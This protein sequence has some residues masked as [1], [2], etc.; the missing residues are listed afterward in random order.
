[1]A[2]SYREYLK[3]KKYGGEGG[4]TPSPTLIS[5]TIN[6]NG[7]YLPEDD[8]ADGY[9]S[10]SVNVPEVSDIAFVPPQKFK[11]NGSNLEDYK[12]FGSDG[13]V[14]ETETGDLPLTFT[15][16]EDKLRDWEIRGNDEPGTEQLFDKSASTSDK[17]VGNNG[18]E[19]TSYGRSHSDYIPVTTGSYYVSNILQANQFYQIVGFDENK[20]FTKIYNFTPLSYTAI[21]GVVNVEETAKYIII[22]YQSMNENDVSVTKGSTAPDHYIPYQQGV[23][24]RT[25][26]VCIAPTAQTKTNDALSVTTDGQGRYN[27]SISQTISTQTEVSFDLP[28]FTM[29][30]SVGQGGNGTFSMFNTTKSGVYIAFYY[31]NTQVEYWYLSEANRQSN[32]YISMGNKQ[33]NKIVF[34]TSGTVYAGTVECAIM[35]T[36]D[37]ILP[38]E[39]TPY[40][41]Q[42]PLTVSQS[43][44]TDKNYNIYIGDSPLTA[45]QSISKTSTGIDI[46]TTEGDNTIGTTLYNKP[47]TSVTYAESGG[48]GEESSGSYSIPVKINS[49][50]TDIPIGDT[51]L[52]EDE[53]VSY[54]E[55]KIY[56]YVDGTLTP[57]DPPSALP[58]IATAN[59]VNELSVETDIQPELVQIGLG[60]PVE[61]IPVALGTKFITAND[62]YDASDDSLDGYSSVTVNVPEK[63]LTTKTITASGTYNAVDDQADGYSSVTVNIR[64]YSEVLDQGLQAVVQEE[65]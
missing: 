58:Q 16:T 50:T 25:K 41:Y 3:M 8:Q 14:T 29:P 49:T 61:L 53:Y 22:N 18:A 40:G 47:E 57:V 39:Y 33:C 21:S 60:I 27:I 42:I 56:R 62:T 28:E 32:N 10:V 31:N 1:M 9:N 51:Q 13:V 43:G 48:V 19:T 46:A 63:V 7:L 30:I 59:G 44:Q 12:I 35:F 36:N 52:M 4:D 65:E 34:R 54:A 5:K 11:S 45:G 6:A 23:G 37:G 17:V 24:E 38:T 15:T 20:Q 55:Q 2:N 26:N 64:P